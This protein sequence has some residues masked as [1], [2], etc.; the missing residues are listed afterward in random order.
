MSKA[1]EVMIAHVEN[2][3]MAYEQEHKELEEA[4]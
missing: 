1:I 4:R 2:L 3:K